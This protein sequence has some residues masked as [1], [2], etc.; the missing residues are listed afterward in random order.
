MFLVDV[1]LGPWQQLVPWPAAC[2]A[3]AGHTALCCGFASGWLHVL[4]PMLSAAHCS[5]MC[6]VLPGSAAGEAIRGCWHKDCRDA[7]NAATN[8]AV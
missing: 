6:D 5:L 7:K 1:E 8:T 4:C 3:L 2:R